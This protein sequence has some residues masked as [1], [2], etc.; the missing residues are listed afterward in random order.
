M[1]IE[2]T[3]SSWWLAYKLTQSFKTYIMTKND[4][5]SL[6]ILRRWYWSANR[7]NGFSQLENNVD[8]VAS[9]F[10]TYKYT[11]RY[12]MFIRKTGATWN[13]IGI[14]LKIITFYIIFSL[15]EDLWCSSHQ[16]IYRNWWSSFQCMQLST[17]CGKNAP[18]ITILRLHINV[19]PWQAR[20]QQ[21][22]D[23]PE[24]AIK[25]SIYLDFCIHS[26]W[27]CFRTDYLDLS[28][29]EHWSNHIWRFLID[30]YFILLRRHSRQNH[31]SDRLHFI[32]DSLFLPLPILNYI[33][34]LNKKIDEFLDEIL[35]YLRS[36]GALL[37]VACSHL[38]IFS[39]S[40]H[41]VVFYGLA[42]IDPIPKC[43]SPFWRILSGFPTT[44]WP[45]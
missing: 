5:Y 20:N 31:Q 33:H 44:L 11:D 29:G 38:L 22:P 45:L 23:T 7:L 12:K 41:L 21:M 10:C 30:W 19:S 16:T 26:G 28:F 35:R 25:F 2:S 43:I 37:R 27:F 36:F 42:Y 14:K 17:W 1:K 32:H 34:R 39:E 13:E 4:E 40:P 18:F 6:W 24:S 15:I 3:Y 8:N 9:T